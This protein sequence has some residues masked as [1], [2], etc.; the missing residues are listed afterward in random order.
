VLTIANCAFVLYQIAT[1][2]F[3]REVIWSDIVE[4]LFVVLFIA[5]VILRIFGE[6]PRIYFKSPWNMYVTF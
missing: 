6:G 4:I 3:N 1:E 2:D 5:E